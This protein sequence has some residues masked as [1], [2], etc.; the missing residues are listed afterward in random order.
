MYRIGPRNVAQC[1]IIIILIALHIF[2]CSMNCILAIH[3]TPSIGKG[4]CLKC[5]LL[6][7]EYEVLCKYGLAKPE[8]H[9]ELVKSFFFY[10]PLI[11]SCP[12]L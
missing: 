10:C 9:R 5:L 1:V 6:N 4:Q 3:R 11:H 8:I 12:D 2:A 7:A